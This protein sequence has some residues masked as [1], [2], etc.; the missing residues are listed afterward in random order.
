VLRAAAPEY[1]HAYLVVVDKK[2]NRF[3][4]RCCSGSEI[5][6]I[7]LLL[8]FIIFPLVYFGLCLPL[9][10]LMSRRKKGRK[11]VI[12]LGTV[13]SHK[14]AEQRWDVLMSFLSFALALAISMYLLDLVMPFRAGP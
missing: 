10:Q 3:Q 5:T 1:C 8:I 12:R 11:F 4:G 14:D 2:G 9:F 13:W 6:A 7:H